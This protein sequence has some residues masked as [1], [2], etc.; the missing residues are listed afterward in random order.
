MPF[1]LCIFRP[2]SLLL[3]LA[4]VIGVSSPVVSADQKSVQPVFDDFPLPKSLTLCGEPMPLN[5]PDV[6][7]MLDREMTISAW[8]RAQVFMWLKR[9]G[10]Y[11]SYIEKRLAK[12]GLP[13]DLK[14]LAVAESSLLPHIRSSKGAIGLWQFMT[15][16][17]K[18]N[19]LRRDHGLR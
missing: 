16:T 12:A 10:R 18:R 2:I 5:N 17:A 9:A 13:K 7:E 1:F 8:D 4:A 14:Y 11:F 15:R 3:A 6:R 19:G